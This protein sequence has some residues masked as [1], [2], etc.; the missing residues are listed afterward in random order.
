MVNLRLKS[1]IINIVENQIKMNEPKCTKETLKRLR[2]SGFSRKESIEQIASV[3][4]EEIYDV[5]KS[6]IPFNRLG[7][8]P[9]QNLKGLGG[10]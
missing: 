5:M 6:H 2:N 1:H 8:L 10:R 9:P 7:H 3:L 4:L